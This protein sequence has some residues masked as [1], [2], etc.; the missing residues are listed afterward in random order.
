MQPRFC[1]TGTLEW[2]IVLRTILVRRAW[3]FVETYLEQQYFPL[4]ISWIEKRSDF[5]VWTERTKVEDRPTG[6]KACL[7]VLKPGMN[8]QRD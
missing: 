1:K 5:N 8:I 4:W 2:S 3:R 6:D 7:H